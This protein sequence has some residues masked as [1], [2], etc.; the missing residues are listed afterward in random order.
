MFLALRP[1]DANEPLFLDRM[2][3]S[4]VCQMFQILQGHIYLISKHFLYLILNNNIYVVVQ[5]IF[6][7]PQFWYFRWF[8]AYPLISCCVL[9]AFAHDDLNLDFLLN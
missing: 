8:N 1:G 7:N 4:I 3:K 9:D 6:H 2:R 5:H